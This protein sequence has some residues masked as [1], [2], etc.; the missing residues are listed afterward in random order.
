MNSYYVE[1]LEKGGLVASGKNPETGLVEVVELPSH[2][3]FIGVQF[4]PELKSTPENPQP[5][6]VAFVQAA[7]EYAARK[8]K[9]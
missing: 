7:L 1:D 6:F 9:A 2:P 5:I 3:F 4:H 8:K